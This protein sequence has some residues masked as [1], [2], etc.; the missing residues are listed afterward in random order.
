MPAIFEY[1][2]VVQEH[3]IDELGHAN[4][5]VYVNWMQA[6]AIAHSTKQGWPSQRYREASRAW[7][8]RTHKIEYLQPAFAG[9]KLTIR[10]WIADMQRASSL[11]CYEIVRDADQAVLSRAE[12][13]WAFIDLE[14]RRP[15]RIPPVVR[16]DFVIVSAAD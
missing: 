4:N 11:R 3:E 13:R 9:D 6:A 10:T 8:A 16:D 5:A 14:T 2:Y 12:T 7:V 1:P 15:S